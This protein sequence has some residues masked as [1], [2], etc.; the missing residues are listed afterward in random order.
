M[1]PC[2]Q[3]ENLLPLMI[4][5]DL[6]AAEKT[7][8]RGHL[9]LCPA[10]REYAGQVGRIQSMLAADQVEVPVAYGSDLVVRIN[11]RMAARDKRAHRR[12]L[13]SVPAL[14]SLAAVVLIAFSIL[15]DADSG[16]GNF[17]AELEGTA[18]FAEMTNTGYFSDPLY[19]N[20]ESSDVGNLDEAR[21]ELQVEALKFVLAEPVLPGMDDYVLATQGLDESEFDQLIEQ[22]KKE[23][24]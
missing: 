21:D 5:G 9:E 12:R 15:H 22:M 4:S 7:G 18:T 23:V 11:A 24:I 20:G 16:T 2:K 19:L 10:C 13:W 8:I 17:L 6:A 3:Y 1:R 14:A